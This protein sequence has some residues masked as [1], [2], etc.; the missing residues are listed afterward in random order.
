MSLVLRSR[1]VAAFG[2]PACV[3][4]SALLR[5]STREIAAF[6][7]ATYLGAP[8]LLL[9]AALLAAYLPARRVASVDP[10]LALRHD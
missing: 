7:P 4:L 3:A 9:A 8:L 5:A 2:L 10:L 1:A 6:D